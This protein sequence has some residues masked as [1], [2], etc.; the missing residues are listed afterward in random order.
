MQRIT[1]NL[2]DIVDS[3]NIFSDVRLEGRVA[4]LTGRDVRDIIE[5][6]LWNKAA[7]SLLWMFA[8]TLPEPALLREGDDIRRQGFMKEFHASQSV[9]SDEQIRDYS[10]MFNYPSLRG[11]PEHI[12][13]ATSRIVPVFA[14]KLNRLGPLYPQVQRKKNTSRESGIL[15][16]QHVPHADPRDVTTKDL[17]VLRAKEGIT[18]GGACEMRSAWKFNDLKPRLYYCLGGR[19]YF[20]S[21]YFKKIA[22]CLMESIPTTEE[23]RRT[24]PERY[25]HQDFDN[26]YVVTWDFESFTT[27][28]SELKYFLYYVSGA[29]REQAVHDVTLFDY[30]LGEVICHPAD[31]LDEYNEKINVQAPFDISRVLGEDYFIMDPSTTYHQQNSGML[32]VP[33]NIGLSTALHGLLTMEIF[34]PQGGVCVGDDAKG[35]SRFHPADYAV[36]EISQ[37]GS[38]H[39]SKFSISEPG[40]PNPYRFLKRAFYREYDGSF[41]RDPLM[42]FPLAPLVDG[43][44]SHRDYFGDKSPEAIFNKVMNQVGALLWSVLNEFDYTEREMDIMALY[45]RQV[46]QRFKMRTS[47]A[48]PGLTT[49]PDGTTVKL[50]VAVPSI[51][52]HKYDPRV[53]DWVDHL[54]RTNV[55]AAYHVPTLVLKTPFSMPHVGDEVLSYNHPLWSAMEDLGYVKT[56]DVFEL[57]FVLAEEDK[58]A[59]KKVIGKIPKGYGKGKLVTVLEE[60][61]DQYR[62]FFITDGFNVYRSAISGML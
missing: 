37:I 22:Q 2:V 5:P 45:L 27:R 34:G 47:G 28:L 56:A 24:H 48:L 51:E 25:L 41:Y 31:L 4:R 50:R 60:I 16:S 30:A 43:H 55:Q 54:L 19:D 29:L 15:Y 6:V 59:M 12:Q 40:D 58:R 35:I 1:P 23:K 17:E 7:R 44:M 14:L 38:I 26:D 61:P 46:Y 57:K 42:V 32:G 21:R 11:L 13:T 62:S 39:P 52:F 20:L 9:F 8:R 10:P 3:Q 33:G 49:L 18:I 53:I 36:H